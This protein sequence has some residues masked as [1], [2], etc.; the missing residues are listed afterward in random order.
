MM[1][2]TDFLKKAVKLQEDRAK[3]YDSPEGERSMEAVVTA[4][5]A[6]FDQDLTVT[7]GWQFMSLLKKRRGHKSKQYHADSFEDDVSYTALAGEEVFR[8]KG[9]IKKCTHIFT[10]PNP[11]YCILCGEANK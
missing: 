10:L 1:K 2:S 6:L 11:N 9:S 4:F 3:E 8:E 5:N 7:Q